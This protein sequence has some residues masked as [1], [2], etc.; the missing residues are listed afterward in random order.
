MGWVDLPTLPRGRRGIPEESP[1]AIALRASLDP[2]YVYLDLTVEEAKEIASVLGV[3]LETR[4]KLLSIPD[5]IP[6]QR[7]RDLRVRFAVPLPSTLLEFL[8]R[9]EAGEFPELEL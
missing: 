9:F 3:E 1:I 6:G 5:S 8:S 7:V 2:R 4:F